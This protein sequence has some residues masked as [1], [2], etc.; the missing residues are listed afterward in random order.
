MKVIEG[1]REGSLN[2]PGI[3]GEQ[4]TKGGSWLWLAA[5]EVRGSWSHAAGE[6][7]SVGAI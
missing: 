3:Q 4:V 7:G 5:M 6:K 2:C 1:M